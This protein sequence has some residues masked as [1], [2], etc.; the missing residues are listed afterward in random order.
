MSNYRLRWWFKFLSHV[1]SLQWLLLCCKKNR[2][3]FL[4]RTFPIFCPAFDKIIGSL[5]SYDDY[6]SENV[7][8]KLNFALSSII[9]DYS[10]L[11]TLYKIG[12]LHF[13]LLGTN[14]FHLKAKNESCELAL[15]SEPQIWKF[16]V[17]FWQI[18]QN[19]ALKS[20]LHVQHDSFSSFNQSNQWFVTFSLTLPSSNRKLPNIMSSSMFAGQVD[21]F[22]CLLSPA[23]KL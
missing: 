12:E 15:P 19:I 21:L 16:H 23:S 20:V 1:F 10:M 8:L 3:S 9:C 18:L 11:I 5:R 6:C 4:G 17:F 22:E 14:G 2:I 13:R 7:T